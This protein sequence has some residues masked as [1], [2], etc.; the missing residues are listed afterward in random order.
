MH[1]ILTGRQYG[2]GKAKDREREIQ[3]EREKERER[4][5]LREGQRLLEKDRNRPNDNPCNTLAINMTGQATRAMLAS[6]PSY[7]TFFDFSL[8]GHWPHPD[9]KAIWTRHGQRETL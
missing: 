5:T 3:R 7:F 4:E 2:Q 1:Q 8:L 9:K 6:N